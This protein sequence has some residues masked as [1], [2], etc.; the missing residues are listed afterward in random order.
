MFGTE[1]FGFPAI[2]NEKSSDIVQHSGRRVG[3]KGA[4]GDSVH[5]RPA[6]HQ[7]HQ[8]QARPCHLQTG[9]FPW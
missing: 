1:G 3:R 9:D 7:R 6:E 5:Q 4:R 8:L 2:P